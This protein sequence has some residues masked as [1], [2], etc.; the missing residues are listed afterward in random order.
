M[1]HAARRPDAG[2]PP[3]QHAA[4]HAVPLHARSRHRCREAAAAAAFGFSGA[5]PTAAER[6]AAIERLAATAPERQLWDDLRALPPGDPP[7]WTTPAASARRT[8]S[9]STPCAPA[10]RSRPARAPTADADVTV[11]LQNGETYVS[12]TSL[13][14]AA[15][16]VRVAVVNRTASPM[17]SPPSRSTTARRCCP[18]DDWGRFA[19][20]PLPGADVAAGE[21]ATLTLD[22][23]RRRV[24]ALARR[25]RHGRPGGDRR[26][27][28]ARPA[29][30]E[31]RADDG[32]R[33]AAAPPG[34]RRRRRPLDLALRRRCASCA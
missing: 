20:T 14:P 22:V 19:W 4:G 31:R 24:R 34:G 11:V 16:R 10:T 12:R 8:A 32:Q 9:S 29:H 6:T 5:D 18:G 33:L 25:R 28:R 21:Q 2:D 26:R 27:A 3:A 23:P 7:S 17:R 13:R 15:G 1:R 30:P